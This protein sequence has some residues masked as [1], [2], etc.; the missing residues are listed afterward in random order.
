MSE[1][2]CR[3]ELP[4]DLDAF[5]RG[6][7]ECAEWCGL[8]EED[9]KAFELAVS[10]SWRTDSLQDTI[11]ECQDFQDANEEM[12]DGLDMAQAGHDFFLT[13]NRHGAGF[14]DRGH[15]ERIGR[16]L[17]DAAHAYGGTN[18]WFDANTETIWEN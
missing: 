17:S 5:T 7:L 1:Y 12:L 14:W 9:R 16:A 18:V 11:D 4:A 8:M 6:Y 10:P 3:A 15:P 13:R 2:V